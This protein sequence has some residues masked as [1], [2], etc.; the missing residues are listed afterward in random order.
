[1]S[2]ETSKQQQITSL[3]EALQ[4]LPPSSLKASLQTLAEPLYRRYPAEDLE[5]QSIDQLQSRLR[6]LLTEL[7]SQSKDTVHVR[8][9]VTG[10]STSID[11]HDGAILVVVCPEMPFCTSSVRGE[12]NRLGADIKALT[13]CNIRVGVDPMGHIQGV[14]D[15]DA[16]AYRVSLLYFELAQLSEELSIDALQ[17]SVTQV[18]QQVTSVVTAFP[19][20]QKQLVNSQVTVAGCSLMDSLTRTEA[21]GLIGWLA[22]GNVTLLGY[23]HVVKTEVESRVELSLGLLAE[24][25]SDAEACFTRISETENA[26]EW[27]SIPIRFSKSVL[28]SKV[29]R[30]AYPDFI[31]VLVIDG[32]GRLVAM[33][34]FLCLLTFSAYNTDPQNIP[35]LRVKVKAILDR[36]GFAPSEHDGRELLRVIELF[37]RD[38]LF[39]SSLDALFET[40]SGINRLQE[41][42]Q[43]RLF[44]RADGDGRFVNC[45]VYVPKDLYNTELRVRMQ[46]YLAAQINPEEAEFSTQFTESILVRIHFTFKCQQE[47]HPTPATDVLEAEIQRIAQGW[48]ERLQACLVSRVGSS[49]AA[50]YYNKVGQ[51][52]SPGYQADFDPE[53]AC[54]D[55]VVLMQLSQHNPITPMLFDAADDIGALSLRLYHYG[56]S[57]PLSDV[58]PVLENLGLRVISERP[59]RVGSGLGDGYWIQEFTLHYRFSASLDIDAIKREFEAAFLAVW[60]H[61]SDNDSFNQLVLGTSLSWRDIAVLRAYARYSKQLGFAYSPEFMANTLAT[62]MALSSL[63]IDAFYVLFEPAYSAPREAALAEL[64]Q[65]FLTGLEGVDNLGEDRVFRH[66]WALL[67]A[68]VRTNFFLPRAEDQACDYLAF[69]FKPACIPDMIHPVPYR[70]IYVYSPTVEGV[71]LRGGPVSRGGLR[72]SDRTEDFRTEVLGLAKAQQ[73]KNS[74]IVPVGAK[75]GFVARNLSPEDTREV[76]QEKGLAAYTLFITALLEITDNQIT[77]AI[78]RSE[79]LVVRDEDDPYLVVAADKGTATFSDTANGVA[80]RFN[81]WLGDAFASGGS[82]GY[83]HKQMGITARGAWVSVTRHFRELGID[84]QRDPV[85]TVGVGDMSGDVFGNGLLQSDALCLVAAFNHMHIFIDPTPDPKVSFAERQRLFQ[86][87]SG[88]WGEYNPALLSAGGAIFHRS[89]KRLQLTPEIQ[90]LIGRN[91]ASMTPNEL[92]QSLLMMPS[93][94]FWNGGIGTY[95]KA[96]SESHL[97]VADKANDALRVNGDELGA[98]V[99]GEGGNL[100]MTQ[101]GRIEYALAGGRCNTDFIDNAGGVDCSDH[102]VNI[103]ILLDNL[104]RQ[105]QLDGATRNQRL[106]GYTDSVARHVLYNNDSQTLALSLIEQ[107][108]PARLLEYRQLIA[109]LSDAN[110]L[111]REQEYLPSDE[112][113]SE[114]R[115]QGL[116]LTRPELALLV[117]ASKSHLKQVL[118]S[119]ELAAVAGLQHWVARSFP[120]QLVAEF[121]DVIVD[122]PLYSSILATQL[123]N[124]MVNK[125][126]PNVLYRQRNATG[127]TALEVAQYYAV[128]TEIFDARGQ[129]RSL[130]K[131]A[132]TSPQHDIYPLLLAYAQ[133][134]KRCL[135]W[136]LRNRVQ[137]ETVKELVDEYQAGVH[138]LIAEY[139]ELITPESRVHTIEKQQSLTALVNDSELARRLV[140]IDQAHVM[141]GLIKSAK[142][143]GLDLRGLA[144]VYFGLG[145]VLELNYLLQSLAAV[146]VDSEWRVQARDS[147]LEEVGALQLSLATRFMTVDTSELDELEQRLQSWL[148]NLGPIQARWCDV[149]TQLKSVEIPDFAVFTVV[150]RELAELARIARSQ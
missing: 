87:S 36:A 48:M 8:C 144:Q 132:P 94:L 16:S 99:V 20:M 108:S 60:N 138:L 101:L 149:I 4:A 96:R 77:G 111:D 119:D 71:H 54:E 22:E 91:E 79:H 131:V 44:L 122:H 37:P 81:F 38:E 7:T 14:I 140:C 95:V 63:L 110:I 17:A 69:K 134:L 123:A 62:H 9:V 135:R 57:L 137:G 84:V 28:R 66:Y 98:R 53:V 100:G 23:E 61:M 12:L 126:G 40:I 83:D 50:T 112:A 80:S 65:Q 121:G 29:H 104:V 25:P 107:D 31:D 106:Q 147:Y 56:Q 85:R 146:A 105:Q 78:E 128:V 114:R 148:V 13:S 67:T 82:Q 115:A 43:T 127:A 15:D 97:Q 145:K 116:G 90:R 88:G 58:L 55:T 64:E 10:E 141:P 59:Y 143:N 34:R 70:E 117:S 52:F 24:H 76:R 86:A 72:W 136:F 125:L 113:I 21:A 74:V 6:F 39:Q 18:M 30:L 47:P 32:G 27:C 45:W 133:M 1:M 3:Q 42:R 46:E 129:W 51:Y 124:D 118:R 49:A 68:T 11:F 75:G 142:I 5:P 33:H 120:S 19:M 35:W 130:S 139:P 26:A 73:V 2:L 109:E 103:K 41:R 92:I 89:A 102:E 150:T 93:D